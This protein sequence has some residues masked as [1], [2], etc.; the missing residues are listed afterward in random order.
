MKKI[1]IFSFL[2]PFLFMILISV[3]K[4]TKNIYFLRHTKFLFLH[5]LLFYFILFFCFGGWA[6]LSPHGL[7]WTPLTQLG[8][9][10]RPVTR[11]GG[12]MHACPMNYNSL[13]TVASEL[14]F[15]AT[16]AVN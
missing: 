1:G 10:S 11:L 12:S 9:W 5:F 4:L 8:H 7:G 16:V 2:F 14:Q 6:Q 3:N 13:A 15:T